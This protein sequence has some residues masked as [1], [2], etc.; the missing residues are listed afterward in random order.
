MGLKQV[1]YSLSSVFVLA[2]SQFFSVVEFLNF[3]RMF[4]VPCICVSFPS[5]RKR[6]FLLTQL[7]VIFLVPEGL[8]SY[9]HL[10]MLFSKKCDIA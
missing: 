2:I 4:P 7:F 5:Q 3:L 9:P 8:N 10:V 6:C 1:S